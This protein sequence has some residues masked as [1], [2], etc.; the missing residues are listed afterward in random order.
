MST[1]L[2][3]TYDKWT[4]VTRVAQRD[5]WDRDDTCSSWTFNSVYAKSPNEWTSRDW[6]KHPTAVKPGDEVHLVIAVYSTGDSFGH[7]ECGSMQI[8]ASYDSYEK[9]AAA[10]NIV[11]TGRP[12]EIVLEDGSVYADTFPAWTGYFESLD[13]VTVESFRVKR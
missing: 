11:E 10:A 6:F 5:E 3:L 8:V 13:Y 2:Y 9:A 4:E 12:Y 1:D 7:D